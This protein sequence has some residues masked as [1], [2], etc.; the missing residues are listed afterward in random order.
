MTV[1]PATA[2]AA[3]TLPLAPA[4]EGVQAERAA[5]ERLLAEGRV[6]PVNDFLRAM[7]AQGNGGG[8][9]GA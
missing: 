9:G 5:A 1:P 3:G 6:K 8:P 4:P 7:L 2:P